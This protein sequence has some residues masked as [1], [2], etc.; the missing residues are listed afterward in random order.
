MGRGMWKQFKIGTKLMKCIVIINH[1]VHRLHMHKWRT[2]KLASNTLPMNAHICKWTINTLIHSIPIP[3]N[4]FPYFRLPWIPCFSIM[5]PIRHTN[6]GIYGL[7][8]LFKY[9]HKC[10]MPW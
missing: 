6:R 9:T 1:L 5:R 2:F 4:H 3:T 8:C 10:T 7:Q